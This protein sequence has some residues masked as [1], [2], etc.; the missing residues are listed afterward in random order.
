MTCDSKPR[1]WAACRSRAT[2]LHAL[3]EGK[4]GPVDDPELVALER[5]VKVMHQV[6]IAVEKWLR[7][8]QA[9]RTDLIV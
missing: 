3:A 8:G 2:R 9:S 7:P 4:L 6:A 1:R 5:K